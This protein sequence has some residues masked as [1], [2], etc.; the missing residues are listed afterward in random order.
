[1]KFFWLPGQNTS[2]FTTLRCYAFMVTSGSEKAGTLIPA[3]ARVLTEW[4][5]PS[6]GS[7]GLWKEDNNTQLL[8]GFIYSLFM[9]CKLSM[10]SMVVYTGWKRSGW[11]MKLYR[12]EDHNRSRSLSTFEVQSQNLSKLTACWFQSSLGWLRRCDH[13]GNRDI[14]NM[15]SFKCWK[16]L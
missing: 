1:M 7:T 6:T 5:W 3:S 2:P 15:C 4:S 11:K 12:K 16:S 8:R 14:V 13:I 10:A 9:F